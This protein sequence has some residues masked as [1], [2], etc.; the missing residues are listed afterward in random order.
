VV[1]IGGCYYLLRVRRAEDHSDDECQ[2][3]DMNFGFFNCCV[4]EL[5]NSWLF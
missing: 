5:N 3:L 1:A 4:E 2:D